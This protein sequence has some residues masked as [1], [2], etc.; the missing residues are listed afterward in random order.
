MTKNLP[1]PEPPPVAEPLDLKALAEA[2]GS[3]AR[4]SAVFGDPITQGNVVIVPVART[5]WG[6]GRGG[7]SRS[8]GGGGMKVEPIG[9]IEVRDCVAAFV[10]IRRKPPSL[11]A[12]AA[13]AVGVALIIKQARA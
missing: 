12:L 13:C 11:I 8:N 2:I 3:S 5:I 6:L 1:V 10:P 7:S 4:A 9:Y